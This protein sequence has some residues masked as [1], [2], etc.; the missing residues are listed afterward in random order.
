MRNK[1]SPRWHTIY[2]IISALV[3]EAAI[4]VLILWV[5]PLFNINIPLWGLLLILAGF[6]VFCYINYRIGHPTIS[7]PEVSAPECIIGSEGEVESELNPDG[8]VRVVGEL[9]KATADGESI[10]RGTIVITTGIEG[11]KLSVRKKQ[12]AS[13]KP[14]TH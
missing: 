6:A 2:S 1:R 12:D 9:W 8:Y 11:L 10:P 4:A 7:Y 5:L 3:E 14:G 13:E